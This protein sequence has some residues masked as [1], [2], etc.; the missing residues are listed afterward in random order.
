MIQNIQ[1]NG[2]NYW[3]YIDRDINLYCFSLCAVL[4]QL[5]SIYKLEFDLLN[6]NL[7]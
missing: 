1:I 5:R 4:E 6:F 2:F 3:Q 7:N